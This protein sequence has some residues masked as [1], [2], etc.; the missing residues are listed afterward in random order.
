MQNEQ[1]NPGAFTFIFYFFVLIIGIFIAL[2]FLDGE[3]SRADIMQYLAATIASISLSATFALGVL[4]INAFGS[5]REVERLKQDAIELQDSL[6]KEVQNTQKMLSVMPSVINHITNMLPEQIPE[7]RRD[8]GDR[9]IVY[10]QLLHSRLFIKLI[11]ATTP[12]D[13]LD[14]CRDIIGSMDESSSREIL[15]H[16]IIELTAI[17]K[18]DLALR[19]LVVPL[20]KEANTIILE[21]P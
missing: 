12:T 19:D 8:S 9:D 14:I 21:M 20:Q 15:E 1:L 4:A 2:S 3:I 10:F 18:E 17:L 16:C 13:R 6:R 11:A 7:D 5:M